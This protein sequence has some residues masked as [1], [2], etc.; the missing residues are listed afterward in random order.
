MNNKIV[1]GEGQSATAVYLLGKWKANTY[2]AGAIGD[3]TELY[4]VVIHIHRV[5]MLQKPNH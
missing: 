3:V 4:T 1:G 5:L 2:Y